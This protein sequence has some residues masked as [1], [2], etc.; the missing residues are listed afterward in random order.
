M[1]RQEVLRERKYE[2]SGFAIDARQISTAGKA[3]KSMA[4]YDRSW[5]G[6]EEEFD[7]GK[8]ETCR[9]SGGRAEHQ[10]RDLAWALICSL[11]EDLLRRP[12]RRRPPFNKL[13]RSR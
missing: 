4:V 13:A 7:A 11:V 6:Q 8:S 2:R 1:A 9:A 12:A 10:A 5:S 3:S